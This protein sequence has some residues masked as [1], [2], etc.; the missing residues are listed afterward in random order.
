MPKH[1]DPIWLNAVA[2]RSSS[3][4]PSCSLPLPVELQGLPANSPPLTRNRVNR[5]VPRALALAFRAP[6]PNGSDSRQRASHGIRPLGVPRFRLDPA[7]PL[8][9]AKAPFGDGLRHPPS[10]SALVV[11]H[12][13]DGFL[14]DGLP[15]LLHLGTGRGSPCFHLTHP[16][17]RS[18]SCVLIA[19]TPLEEFP[20]PVAV[21]HHCGRCLL[22]VHA[23]RTTHHTRTAG[24]P[25][26]CSC[27]VKHTRDGR[28]ARVRSSRLSAL[29]GRPTLGTEGALDV[30]LARRLTHEPHTSG[31]TPSCGRAE[32]THLTVDT[33]IRRPRAR[34]SR[35]HRC[36]RFSLPARITSRMPAQ[37]AAT[38][39]WPPGTSRASEDTWA[40]TSA[41]PSSLEAAAS[42]ARAPL[43]STTDPSSRPNQPSETAA[44]PGLSRYRVSGR[45]HAPSVLSL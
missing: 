18:G 28:P 41:A 43:A 21:P 31:A 34:A 14:Q 38:R 33:V 15:S 4:L 37:R 35:V 32:R 20:S 1:R 23:T 5:S 36:T 29:A 11:L 19:L 25:S 9:G 40:N 45:L 7:C 2:A 16:V 12:H 22:A 6:P 13:L 3:L 30:V 10:R 27:T 24:R 44:A 42:N 26:S 8:P 17:T 39:R